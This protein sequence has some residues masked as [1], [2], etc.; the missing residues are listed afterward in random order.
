MKFAAMITLGFAV[1]GIFVCY[2]MLRDE[3]YVASYAGGGFGILFGL[4]SGFL[5]MSHFTTQGTLG[6]LNMLLVCGCFVIALASVVM[7]TMAFLRERQF[8]KMKAL[9]KQR[10]KELGVEP[11][12]DPEDDRL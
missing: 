7:A 8:K 2:F 11:I 10:E 5:F 1:I 12:A 6:G 4:V 3:V 9:R